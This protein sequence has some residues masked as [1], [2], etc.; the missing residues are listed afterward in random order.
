MSRPPLRKWLPI[1]R[2]PARSQSQWNRVYQF[3]GPTQVELRWKSRPQVQ[4]IPL[5]TIHPRSLYSGSCTLQ[6]S[7]IGSKLQNTTETEI[8]TYSCSY[9]N[10]ER[11]R[12]WEIGS[13]T[14]LTAP[15]R[16]TCLW[17]SPLSQLF[18]S[19]AVCAESMKFSHATG[20]ITTC[21]S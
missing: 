6:V 8:K 9:R 4:L 17:I 20:G 11:C 13:N 2:F 12:A 15:T 21:Q 14:A 1:N 19:I 5:M 10:R 16:I 3:W 7:S 18:M